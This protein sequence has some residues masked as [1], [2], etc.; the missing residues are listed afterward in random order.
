[1]STQPYVIEK[2]VNKERDDLEKSPQGQF[3]ERKN[4]PLLLQIT[5]SPCIF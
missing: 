2:P 4:Y 3:M 1:M 5:R